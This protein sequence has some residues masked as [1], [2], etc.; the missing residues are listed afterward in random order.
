[1]KFLP[2]CVVVASAALFALGDTIE[3]RNPTDGT[4]LPINQNFTAQVVL[5]VR[6]PPPP[7]T[8]A[9]WVLTR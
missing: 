4:V 7:P 5:P 3:L 9:L 8:S 2:L 1:M 6:C